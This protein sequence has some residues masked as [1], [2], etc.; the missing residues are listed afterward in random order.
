M[1]RFEF[2]ESVA[3]RVEGPVLMVPAAGELD[4]VLNDDASDSRVR[5]SGPIPCFASAR[6]KVI[7]G[8]SLAWMG[9][10]ESSGTIW[11]TRTWQGFVFLKSS[12]G[13]CVNI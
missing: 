1:A 13:K 10:K 8:V 7:Q 6:A 2:G 3:L 9:I 12:L 5:G 11:E 4:A